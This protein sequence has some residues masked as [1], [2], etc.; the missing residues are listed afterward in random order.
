MSEL[1]FR[2]V[3]K[4]SKDYSLNKLSF[5]LKPGEIF[6]LLCQ[7]QKGS[8]VMVE[9][10]GGVVGPDQGKVLY[11]QRKISSGD[12]KH[13]VKMGMV[14]R[15]VFFYENLTGYENLKL[16]LKS[17]RRFKTYKEYRAMLEAVDY[18]FD[19]LNMTS[20]KDTLVGKYD[21]GTIQKLKFIRAMMIIPECVVLEEPFS[22]LDS[23]TVQVM[24]EH[25]NKKSQQEGLSVLILTS[26]LAQVVH[27][28]QKIAM[29]HNGNIRDTVSREELLNRQKSFILIQTDDMPR[30]LLHLE[31]DLLIF[32]YELLTDQELR[33]Y[34]DLDSANA[35]FQLCYKEKISLRKVKNGYDTIESYFLN[36]IG[37]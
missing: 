7:N 12:Y 11:R 5:T 18:Y 13:L 19:L 6:T 32:D 8:Q 10:I 24:M 25:L 26:T 15:S 30:L 29:I 37:D 36:Q 17:Y 34:D 31:K 28:S 4:K 3:S 27:Y 14:T 22:F 2:N 16:I 20:F 21:L 1:I 33:V 23:L 35:I 9:L